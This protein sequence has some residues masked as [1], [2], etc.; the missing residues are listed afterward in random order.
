MEEYDIEIYEDLSNIPSEFLTQA[1]DDIKK[2]EKLPG[3]EVDLYNWFYFQ[4]NTCYV[5]LAGASLYQRTNIASKNKYD[6]DLLI[7]DILGNKENYINIGLKLLML[8][9]LRK[10]AIELFLETLSDN[11]N[12][13]K[14]IQ[15]FERKFKLER[16]I[17]PYEEDRDEFFEQ[18][19]QL[20]EDLKSV[21]L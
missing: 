5:C 11:F 20:V 6:I 8:N 19:Y 10:G 16:I 3:V 1:L 7:N 4:D 14:Q 2:C 13:D 12:F 17:T 15:E 9:D 18:M 21:G